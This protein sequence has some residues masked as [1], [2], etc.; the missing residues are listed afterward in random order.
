[1]LTL[2]A[3]CQPQVRAPDKASPVMTTPASPT[4]P[5]ALEEV[6]AYPLP[7]V[8]GPQAL[9]FTPDGRAIVYLRS[10]ERTLV[11]QLYRRDLTTGEETLLVTPPD[12]GATEDNLS[13]EE[14]LRRERMRQRELGVTSYAWAERGD[15][16]L[17][18]LTGKIYVKQPDQP[19]LRLLVDPGPDGPPALDPR[20]SPDGRQVAYVQ[21]DELYVVPAG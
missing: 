9:T 10:P 14:K 5:L 1:C 2:A 4:P 7:A 21:D 6:A 12:G 18:P 17:I 15:T 13:L 20:L 8:T 16:M 19:D 11:R 3:A